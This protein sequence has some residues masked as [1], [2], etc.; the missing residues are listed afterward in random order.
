MPSEQTGETQRVP[1]PRRRKDTSGPIVFILIVATIIFLAT[2]EAHN[3]EERQTLSGDPTFSSYAFLSGVET[4][5]NSSTFRGGSASAV[6]G[7]AKLDFR[8]ATMEGDQA[9]IDISAIMG[10][11]ELY[12]PRTWEVVNHIVP[13]LGGVNDHTSQRD[14][15]KRLIVEGTVLMGGLDIR[16]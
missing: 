2:N 11:V 6:M 5:N 12:V 1:H 7:G 3:A 13:V 14:A 16:N 15:S 8:E 9:T 4:R 10:G